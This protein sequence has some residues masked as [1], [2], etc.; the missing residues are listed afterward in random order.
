MRFYGSGEKGKP[1]IF[2]FPGTCCLWTSFDHVLE[3]LHKS[4]YTV[5]VSY[6]G[7]DPKEKTEF[8]SMLEEC[9]K[10]E[11]EVRKNYG[12]KI[13]A[14][15]GCSLGGSFVAL[16]IQRKKIT[17][18][19]GIIG[20]S[21]MDEA[22]PL[23]AKLESALMLPILYPMVKKGELSGWMK[24]R[25]DKNADPGKK[26]LMEKFCG[27]FGIGKGGCPWITKKTICNQF[28]SDLV[29]K[30]DHGIAV[31]GTTIHVFYALKM[32]EKY[33]ERYHLYFKN[34][35]IREFD[36]QHEELFCCQP[37]RWAEEVVECCK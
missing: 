17:I 21:D 35:D 15:Y 14:A 32:G 20:S 28:Y 22:G 34:P 2:L 30:V 16:L 36:L 29:T 26:E 12:G 27:M 19:H 9:E 13:K 4:F 10:I 18:E 24:K 31:P 7:F 5:V 25:M 3:E 8:S 23:L 33:R 11:A 1:V 37:V 6:D